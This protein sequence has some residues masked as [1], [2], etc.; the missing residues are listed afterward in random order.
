MFKSIG[1]RTQPI[2]NWL[3][4][5][6]KG[7]LEVRLPILFEKGASY[8]SVQVDND[9]ALGLY[10]EL[11]LN[12]RWEILNCYADFL[13]NYHPHLDVVTLHLMVNTLATL[14]YRKCTYD[15][16]ED[17]K[18]F[19]ERNLCK[20]CYRITNHLFTH[21]KVEYYVGENFK[22]YSKA[23][24]ICYK[25][26][27][28][29][30]DAKK[31]ALLL[32]SAGYGYVPA[33]YELGVFYAS[34][35]REEDSLKWHLEASKYL[36]A[37]SL[38]Y[39]V[40]YYQGTPNEVEYLVK[41]ASL[42]LVQ[43]LDKS[44]RLVEV[45]EKELSVSSLG[46]WER[47]QKAKLIFETLSEIILSQSDIEKDNIE[48]VN[49]ARRMLARL[50]LEKKINCDGV[51]AQLLYELSRTERDELESSINKYRKEELISI[52]NR[53]NRKITNALNSENRRL[54]VIQR[55][56]YA[57]KEVLIKARREE[58]ERLKRE[59][60][61]LEARRKEEAEALE[62][63]RQEARERK[64]YEDPLNLNQKADYKRKPE[65]S[66][67]LYEA[68]VKLYEKAL[69]TCGEDAVLEAVTLSAESGHPKAMEALARYYH[70]MDE[71]EAKRYLEKC[72]EWGYADDVFKSGG[73][74]WT[75]ETCLIYIDSARPYV[76]E[77]AGQALKKIGIKKLDIDELL[78]IKSLADASNP[79]AIRIYA[80]Y[81]KDS[82]RDEWFRYACMLAKEGD[83]GA[84]KEIISFMGDITENYSETY[85]N[86]LQDEKVKEN[87]H[88]KWQWYKALTSVYIC[89]K[90]GFK[91]SDSASLKHLFDL[92]KCVQD[93]DLKR[94]VRLELGRCHEYGIGTTVQYWM[95]S[96]YYR[97]YDDN[98]ADYFMREF[99]R[100]NKE[101][102]LRTQ[103]I[104]RERMERE[105]A[106]KERIALEEA[107]LKEREKQIA[108]EK[109]T[110]I[111][112]NSLSP[113]ST[114]NMG[115]NV[116]TATNKREK[117]ANALNEVRRKYGYNPDGNYND[118]LEYFFRMCSGP[119]VNKFLCQGEGYLKEEM[120]K[121]LGVPVERVITDQEFEVKLQTAVER[122][123]GCCP[124]VTIRNM[125]YN[126]NYHKY[127][128][129]E[130]A[131][132][133]VYA[134]TLNIAVDFLQ[135]V[136]YFSPTSSSIFYEEYDA[137][138]NHELSKWVT[139]DEYAREA[140]V[141]LRDY[142]QRMDEEINGKRGARALCRTIAS[143]LFSAYKVIRIQ[144]MNVKKGFKAY[145]ALVA[146]IPTKVK[147][148]EFN[149]YGN[150]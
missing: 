113:Q 46:E 45:L 90:L 93:E 116:S 70:R 9:V 67:S 20:E 138:M 98:R 130:I 40:E 75:K 61:E 71:R 100:I 117:E 37:D 22:K 53:L 57:K 121:I 5:W 74:K 1:D 18:M 66:L 19:S 149:F 89:T 8:S 125:G 132:L 107:R 36:Y 3:N 49:K 135:D 26:K 7:E 21:P 133:P 50:I 143:T 76:R 145:G 63:A 56:E 27:E 150:Q 12:N 38:N 128:E 39:L 73:W 72:D 110:L 2:N 80:D 81:V 102:N 43:Y 51:L 103:K 105:R 88:A 94:L 64:A 41:L 32:K 84:I 99:N 78:K 10:R 111:T 144:P 69:A 108:L 96:K 112:P 129:R 16:S 119:E 139:F 11:V 124:T 24:D 35:G 147:I 97:G 126:V 82:N 141:W 54:G 136:R 123:V 137:F 106:E 79:T 134:G 44:F 23:R 55:E 86:F 28:K 131:G 25:A 114:Q 115:N 31:E 109:S 14:G 142:E 122:Y 95:A 29:K 87:E 59:K 104:E 17:L 68:N 65:E 47:E 62:R 48:E 33:Y 4:S 127:L 34:L 15:P 101:E 6:L 120:A 42:G 30:K 92:N 148:G 85:I 146:C 77:R 140:G 83:G 13:N 118:H 58:E 91:Q 52:R 60:E